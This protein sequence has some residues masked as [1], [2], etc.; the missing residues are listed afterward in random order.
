MELNSEMADLLSKVSD[1]FRTVNAEAVTT[2]QKVQMEQFWAISAAAV[3]RIVHAFSVPATELKMLLST[4]QTKGFQQASAENACEPGLPI[5]K[6]FVP[7]REQILVST[8]DSWST[9][10]HDEYMGKLFPWT[11]LRDAM[12]AMWMQ[13]SEAKQKMNM[14]FHLDVEPLRF[15]CFEYPAPWYRPNLAVDQL[16]QV[17]RAFI[18]SNLRETMEKRFADWQQV[19]DFSLWFQWQKTAPGNPATKMFEVGFDLSDGTAFTYLSKSCDDFLQEGF[20]HW[21]QM[22]PTMSHDFKGLLESNNPFP[23]LKMATTDTWE[24]KLKDQ[25]V[26][27][28]L[29]SFFMKA[30]CPFNVLTAP[31]E[32]IS[33]WESTLRRI[34]EANAELVK[35][36]AFAER[37]Q[38]VHESVPGVFKELFLLFGTLQSTVEKARRGVFETIHKSLN[39]SVLELGTKHK[40][41]E[42]HTLL[43]EVGKTNII[44]SRAKALYQKCCCP[45]V[46]AFVTSF[47]AS[48]ESMAMATQ[49]LNSTSLPLI[50]GNYASEFQ[51]RIEGLEKAQKPFLETCAGVAIMT[52]LWR[53]LGPMERRADVVHSTRSLLTHITLPEQ[54]QQLM[55]FAEN[56]QVC[57]F[58]AK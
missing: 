37:F 21:F 22:P 46:E 6:L 11:E 38:H 24:M 23:S 52:S 3:K 7:T 54:L 5:D 2:I 28:R 41:P 30:V 10:C 14:S 43:E 27:M 31:F 35:Y 56:G 29:V 17:G 16:V 4:I 57:Y 44:K 58:Q 47:N 32:V 13:V 19:S 40:L 20:L 18:R 49:C 53:G 34:E 50:P 48:R 42:V 26:D 39:A 51:L 12:Q 15:F 1:S 36:K 33:S 45:A 55:T 8:F 9:D 25:M